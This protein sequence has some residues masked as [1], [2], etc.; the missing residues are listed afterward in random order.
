MTQLGSYILGSGGDDPLD[1]RILSGLDLTQTIIAYTIVVPQTL[2]LTQT[3]SYSIAQ[4]EPLQSNLNLTQNIGYDFVTSSIIRTAF[5]RCID[6]V[7]GI[8]QEITTELGR[9]NHYFIVS[10]LEL[11]QPCIVSE[12]S[13]STSL[14]N[15]SITHNLDLE[16]LF[17]HSFGPIGTIHE[18]SITSTLSLTQSIIKTLGDVLEE[19]IDQTLLLTQSIIV[20]Q[21]VIF[22][23]NL[24]LTDLITYSFGTILSESFTSTLSLTQD[25]DYQLITGLHQ[26]PTDTLSLTQSI[27]GSRIMNRE[28]S[29]SLTLSQ[30]FTKNRTINQSVSSILDL[31]DSLVNVIVFSRSLSDTLQFHEVSYPVFLNYY[32]HF[33]APIISYTVNQNQ[34]QCP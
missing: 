13:H 18:R 1:Q 7:L 22:S 30:S 4:Y 17:N 3:I 32:E 21:D 9:T 25:I 8:T 16:Q 34:N 29:N 27:V 28:L 26:Y 31:E 33:D 11:R 12:L 23:D 19:S 10:Q 14:F 24:S 15:R 6:D 2:T 20:F 5:Q